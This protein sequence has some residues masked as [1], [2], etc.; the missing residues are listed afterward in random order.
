MVLAPE[1][2]PQSDPSVSRPPGDRLE[3]GRPSGAGSG[4]LL[5]WGGRSVRP[6]LDSDAALRLKKSHL[7]EVE[8]AQPLR[9]GAVITVVADAASVGLDAG[10]IRHDG[11][12]FVA[13]VLSQASQ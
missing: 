8:N 10:S 6:R 11:T 7:S 2:R 9:G 3:R 13:P 12:V 1:G 4:D 5:S